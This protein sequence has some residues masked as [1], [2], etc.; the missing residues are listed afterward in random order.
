MKTY[1]VVAVAALTDTNPA[2]PMT[3]QFVPHRLRSS[4]VCIVSCSPLC[5]P[6]SHPLIE[7]RLAFMIAGGDVW[8]D[9]WESMTIEELF[10]LRE[11]MQDVLSEKLKARKAE[12]E[13]RLQTLN[14]PSNDVGSTKSR[15]Q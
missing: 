10:E 2:G 12:I 9:D 15:D 5:C 14:Q 13:R 8:S 3:M 7:N 1:G 11:L 4:A 6:N